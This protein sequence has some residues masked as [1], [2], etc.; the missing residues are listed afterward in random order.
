VAGWGF[1]GRSAGSPASKRRED[2]LLARAAARPVSARNEL[3]ALKATLRYAQ[4]RGHVFDPSLL[5]IEPISTPNHEGRAL[6]VSELEFLASHAPSYAFRLV[7]LAGT[8]GNRISELFTL[9]DDRVDLRNRMLVIRADLCKERRRKLISL[10]I[11]ET[12]LLREQ[13]VARAAGSTL[14]FPKRHGSQW[15]YSS[16]QKL[17]W[18]PTLR[19]AAEAWS[20]ERGAQEPFS[21]LTCH[22][23]RHTAAS[24]MR[25]A[26]IPAELVAERLG[27]ADGG[28]L[29]LKT[30]RH[31]REGE[32]RAA[33][34]A[35][36]HGLRA[37]ARPTAEE[38][39]DA[40]VR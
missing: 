16:F 12:Q 7:L 39:A 32:T 26:G 38:K 1:R 37:A 3:Q 15:S 27:H 25:Q 14:V 29:L 23:L 11:E 33:L 22:D 24:L 30:Y 10:T 2:I 13:L 31:A 6:S 8:T 5:T 21:G 17:V 35:L 40:A 18:R 36:G 9:T 19:D 34:D 28:A 4:A 20:R